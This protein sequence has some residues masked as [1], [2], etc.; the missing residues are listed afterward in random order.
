M[1]ILFYSI[2]IHV[3]HLLLQI[4]FEDSTSSLYKFYELFLVLIMELTHHYE[5]ICGHKYN[6]ILGLGIL[7]SIEVIIV[8]A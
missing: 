3:E 6:N 8:V 2:D 4:Q 5:E 1:V 7:F